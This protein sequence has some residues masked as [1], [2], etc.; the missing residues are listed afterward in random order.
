MKFEILSMAKKNF[1]KIRACMHKAKTCT[2][3]LNFLSTQWMEFEEILELRG[4]GSP[5]NRKPSKNWKSSR[6]K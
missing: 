4:K 1:S 6:L 2:H 5:Q 3:L